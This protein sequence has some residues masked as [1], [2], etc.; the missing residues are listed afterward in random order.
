MAEII[1]ARLTEE[2]S[3][4]GPLAGGI[5]SK[6]TSVLNTGF[7]LPDKTE[8]LITVMPPRFSGI[9]DSLVVSER[10][11]SR[12]CR[13][14][15]G[16]RVLKNGLF[17][18]FEGVDEVL[19]GSPGCLRSSF[20]EQA[21][22]ESPESAGDPHCRAFL[23]ALETFRME[24]GKADGFSYFTQSRRNETFF[25]LQKV[26]ASATIGD[27][28][29]AVEAALRCVGAGIGLTPSADDALVGIQAFFKCLQVYR[30]APVASIDIWHGLFG[31][32]T[33]GTSR[34]YYRCASE[35]RFSQLLLDLI[36]ALHSRPDRL[37]DC[38]RRLSRVGSTSGMDMLAGV[39]TA[40]FCFENSFATH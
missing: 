36:D 12:L 24:S 7:T 8:R 21:G 30:K 4:L 33:T 23:D 31:G 19:E 17:F 27:E 11:F 2:F 6:F 26:C 38:I 13:L 29:R 22:R 1:E 9:P 28:A 15:A 35:G 14:P 16:S 39:E 5:T 37:P 18:D 40:C 34:K 10:F 32:E 25:W 20:F 3:V